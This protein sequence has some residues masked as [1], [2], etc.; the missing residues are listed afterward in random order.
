MDGVTIVALGAI[1]GIAVLAI[2]VVAAAAIRNRQRSWGVQ[3]YALGQGWTY[4]A[5]DPTANKICSAIPVF[6]LSAH[7]RD[8][9]TGEH[10]SVPFM[11]FTLVPGREGHPG[12][13]SRHVSGAGVIALRTPGTI[14]PVIL[15]PQGFVERISAALGGQ[16]ILTGRDEV[17][18][19][20][21]IRGDEPTVLQVLTD[22]LLDWLTDPE[23]SG[24]YGFENGYVVTW[25]VERFAPG[26]IEHYLN[27]LEALTE[28]VPGQVWG[29]R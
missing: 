22:P 2:L 16:D 1:A 15:T 3:A 9:V 13:A 11:A 18:S 19:A 26:D 10:N 7:A 8:V 5:S 21:R 27:K 12:D 23:T 28:L 25:S 6:G 17:D 20:W 24:S 14:E 29:L 4:A